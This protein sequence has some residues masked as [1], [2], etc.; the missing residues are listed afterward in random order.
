MVTPCMPFYVMSVTID[1]VNDIN[2]CTHALSGRYLAIPSVTSS[3][4]LLA[5]LVNSEMGPSLLSS[6]VR[7]IFEGAK[8]A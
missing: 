7:K 2:Y 6:S 4:T 5:I 8:S 3:F 1:V